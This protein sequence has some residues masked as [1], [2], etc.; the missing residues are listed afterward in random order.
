MRNWNIGI[1]TMRNVWQ[2]HLSRR[3][4]TVK[5]VLYEGCYKA[6][7]S[8][9]DKLKKIFTEMSFNQILQFFI[10]GVLNTYSLSNNSSSIW[11]LSPIN[12]FYTKVFGVPEWCSIIFGRSGLWFHNVSPI[13]PHETFSVLQEPSELNIFRKQ[14][15]LW[16]GYFD[17]I[18]KAIF[19]F[20]SGLMEKAFQL[21]LY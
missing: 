17:S 3:S 4:T 14:I 7:V 15:L 10:R 16:A 2:H 11:Q 8:S 9:Y 12:L 20:F 13:I 19:L 18:K 5:K 21:G 1:L 6:L